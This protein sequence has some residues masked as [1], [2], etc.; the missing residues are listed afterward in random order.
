MS[1]RSAGTFVT[2]VYAVYDPDR[3]TLAWANAGHPPP[4]LVRAGGGTTA[5]L[6]GERCVPLGILDGTAYPEAEVNLA[7]GDRVLLHTDGVT[8]AKNGADEAFGD[9]RLD[10]T[11]ARKANGSRAVIGGVLD[12]LETFT[13]G[14]PPAD[15]YTLL[16]MTF[17][18]SRKKAGEI[19]GEWRAVG[20]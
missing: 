7:P 10:A 14:S 20:Q 5:P 6:T 13:G 15:D 3:A 1:T 4:R 12:A 2:A 9:D 8:D 19:S 18:R 11:L 17:V 16:A